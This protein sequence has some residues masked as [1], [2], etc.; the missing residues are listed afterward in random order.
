MHV[1]SSGVSMW[2]RPLVTAQAVQ[3]KV[4]HATSLLCD[5][6][7]MAWSPHAPVLA[8]QG[9]PVWKALLDD[10]NVRGLVMDDVTAQNLF[11]HVESSTKDKLEAMLETRTQQ[12]EAQ[13]QQQ[14]AL[15][16]DQ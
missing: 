14:Q 6:V 12:Q 4:A 11:E 9:S 10:A 13:Q 5:S 16:Q 8:M 2:M 15:E 7:S 3:L 1:G